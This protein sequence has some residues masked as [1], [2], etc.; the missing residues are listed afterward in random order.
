[1]C[2]ERQRSRS[3][4]LTN[5]RHRR[6]H[7]HPKSRTNNIEKIDAG[8][9]FF[10]DGSTLVP[11][12]AP[13]L[14]KALQTSL[15]GGMLES[16]SD[17]NPSISFPVTPRDNKQFTTKVTYLSTDYQFIRRG[18]YFVEDSTANTEY[19]F[20]A[21]YCKVKAHDGVPVDAFKW[22]TWL[23]AHAHSNNEVRM[24]CPSLASGTY[25]CRTR[26]CNSEGKE[27]SDWSEESAEFVI[28]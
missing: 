5:P 18:P 14:E 13:V 16:L 3:C 4:K 28:V 27:Q 1:M 26:Y 10:S 17:T 21:S 24:I 8:D 15:V 25:I 23:M 6:R 2:V 11:P 9:H 20:E 7:Q 19:N 22:K 12:Y